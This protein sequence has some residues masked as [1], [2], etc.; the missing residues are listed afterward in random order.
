MSM[1]RSESGYSQLVALVAVA[2]VLVA[3]YLAKVILL[4][5]ALAV[6]LSFLLTPLVR[7]LERLGAPRVPAVLVVAIL[8][9]TVIGV[10][11]LGR[12]SPGY[13]P[14]Y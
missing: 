9:F 13:R 11:R 10:D 3:L 12:H 14:E 4:P 8:A 7:R 5:F 2:L 1:D 6:L